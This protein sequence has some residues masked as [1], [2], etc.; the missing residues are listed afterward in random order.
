MKYFNDCKSPQQV[1]D[2]FKKLAFQFHPDITGRDTNEEMAAVINEYHKVLQSFDGYSFVGSDKK[3]H[4]YTYKE[5][6]ESAIVDTINELLRHN[7]EGIT[8]EVVG[9]WLWV[10]GNTYPHKAI[11]KSAGLRWHSR[12]QMW[13]R[14]PAGAKS[15]YNSRVSFNELKHYY[16]AEEVS[17]SDSEKQKA[18]PQ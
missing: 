17:G 3:S 9:T 6:V 12:R 7:L 14:A 15:R 11:L 1:K 10:H 2:L 16:G 18:L 5:K 13:Y 8:I 4:K